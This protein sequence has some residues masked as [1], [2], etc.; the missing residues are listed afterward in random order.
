MEQN[1]HSSCYTR[2]AKYLENMLATSVRAVKAFSRV[3]GARKAASKV[4]L[5]F[6]LLFSLL[7]DPP[8]FS[9]CHPLKY[10]ASLLLSIQWLNVRV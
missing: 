7:Q 3:S 4:R 2:S 5:A 1:D 8:G 6:S 10:L 9:P